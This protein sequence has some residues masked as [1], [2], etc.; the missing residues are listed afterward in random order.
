[1]CTFEIY[2]SLCPN[3]T[4]TLDVVNYQVYKTVAFRPFIFHHS[5]FDNLPYLQLTRAQLVLLL[6]RLHFPSF[7]MFS[8]SAHFFFHYHNLFNCPHAHYQ[9]RKFSNLSPHVGWRFKFKPANHST[10]CS[11]VTHNR[12]ARSRDGVN[13]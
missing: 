3:P 8:N 6:E 2:S 13:P 10:T 9:L 7:L 12:T 1:M 5:Q 4:R 11:H